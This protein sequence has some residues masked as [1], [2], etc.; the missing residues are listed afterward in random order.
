M[1]Q[2]EDLLL[3]ILTEELPPKALSTLGFALK[4][5]MEKQL[6]KANLSFETSQVYMTPRRLA[7]LIST[8]KAE[9][10]DQTI[11]RKGPAVKAAFGQDGKP[12]PACLGFARSCGVDA[13][14]LTIIK[15]PQGEWVGLTEKLPGKRTVD[16]LP[17]MVQQSL[18]VLP[19]PKRMRWGEN[20]E[21]FIRPVHG[22]MLLFG[23]SLVKANF[24]GHET[25]SFTVGHRFH[26]PKPIKI[27]QPSKYAEILEK[28]GYVIADFEKRKALIRDQA[29]KSVKQSL[30][31]S[32]QILWDEALLQEVTGLVEWPVA[33]CGHFDLDFLNL[34]APVLISAM[35]DHQRYFPVADH[36]GKLLPNFVTI[37]NIHSKDMPRVIAGNERVLR[38]R[39]SD[40]NF[41]FEM[42]KKKS[43]NERVELL[44]GIIFQAKLGT[45]YDKTQ[46]LIK[47][48]DTIAPDLKSLSRAAHLAK[49]DLTTNMVGEF[50]ELQGIMGY[51]YAIAEGE[52]E[53]VA[54][55][56]QEYYK[57]RFSG[58]DL[59]FDKIGCILALAD[60][61]DTLVGVFGINQIPTGEK[62]PFGLR[63]AAIGVLRILIEKQM[64]IDLLPL[65]Q[66]AFSYYSHL[67][68]KET[69]PA[70]LHFMQERL[71]VLYQ[72]RGVTP[73]VF[74][75]VAA[76]NITCPHDF[77]KRIQAVKFFKELPNAQ[78]LAQ[79]NKRVSNI[80]DQ[81]TFESSAKLDHSLFEED[82]EKALARCLAEKAS[83]IEPLYQAAQYVEVLKALADLRQPI[84]QFFDHMLV[85]AEDKKIRENR[86]L[87]LSH[88]RALFL[89]V[90]DVA[91]LVI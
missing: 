28:K 73:D 8:V 38:A 67:E 41:F 81:C 84:D 30:V 15:T 39:L 91:L 24:F 47:I 16:L 14:T 83:Q 53:A 79:A 1:S 12:T 45:L 87:M 7:L 76:L 49:A 42:D 90:A 9:Q 2:Y 17:G 56:I 86:L 23:K 66:N 59:P 21:S 11:E 40:A 74:S 50:P 69:I 61:I 82:T 35:Q 32:A 54:K 36:H 62:D 10:E 75:A 63:R 20:T 77:D 78:S 5:E 37:L 3:E 64:N 55:A 19:I 29:E 68:N 4:Q 71:K 25:R 48:C 65:L 80:L 18:A 58:D 46:R 34:P 26:Y 44:K 13:S 22:V 27:T 51:Y 31:D 72:E 33:I 88:L 60:R 52:E 70:V 85:M 43:L 89:Q 6:Q 57:P